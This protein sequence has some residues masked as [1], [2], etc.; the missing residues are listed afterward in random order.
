MSS[1]QGLG[2]GNG[3]SRGGGGVGFRV[4]AAVAD[5]FPGGGVGFPGGGGGRQQGGD[6]L[7]VETMAAANAE[8]QCAGNRR[9]PFKKRCVRS[10]RK[11]E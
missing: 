5:W 9:C 8:Q 1:G 6:I 3:R 7:A 11:T 10:R 4:V 2:N